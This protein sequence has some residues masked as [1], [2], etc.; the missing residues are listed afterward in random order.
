[1]RRIVPDVRNFGTYRLRVLLAI[2]GHGETHLPMLF[3]EGPG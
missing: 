1:M 2:S 3:C